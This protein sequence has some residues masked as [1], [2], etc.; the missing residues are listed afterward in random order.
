[1]PTTSIPIFDLYGETQGIPTSGLVHVETLHV[2]AHVHAWTILAH[3]HA[4]LSQFFFI[5]RGGGIVGIDGVERSFEAP[6]ILWLPA[7]V[8][9]SFRFAPETDG[10]VATI[11]ADALALVLRFSAD[12][13]P[14]L[15]APVLISQAPDAASSSVASHLSAILDEDRASET[16]SRTAT[17]HHFGL[18]VIALCRASDPLA[19][20]PATAAH[21]LV[22]A[23]RS[24]IDQQF[25]SRLRIPDYANAL[26]VGVDRLHSACIAVAAMPPSAILHQRIMIEARRALIYTTMSVSDIAYDLGFDDPAYFS[27]FFSRRAGCSPNAFRASPQ[28]RPE[29]KTAGG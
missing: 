19:A 13:M 23:Y 16:A 20:A 27:R 11:A 6:A 21:Q 24:L 22:R 10:I 4:N 3:R 18:A 17:L 5:A 2:R 25:R 14:Q 9:H 1:M 8:V 7:G 15:D 12:R 26:G 29:N 28:G